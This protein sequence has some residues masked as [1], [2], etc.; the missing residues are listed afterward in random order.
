MIFAGREYE[1]IPITMTTTRP[2][3]YRKHYPNQITALSL[4]GPP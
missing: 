3:W 4:A 2:K 1:M